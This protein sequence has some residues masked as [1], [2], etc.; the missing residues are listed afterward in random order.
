VD[1]GYDVSDYM[2]IDP[3]YG[4]MA[5]FDR[6]VAEAGK[7]NIRVICD[8]VVNHTSDR[9]RW[10]QES[11]TSRNNPKADWYVWRD[12]GWFGRLPN[13]WLSIFGHSA[14]QYDAARKQFYYHAFYKEQPDLNWRNPAV[15]KAMY[16]VM[17]F[18]MKRGVAGFRL[19]AVT[20][21]FEDPKLRDEAVGPDHVAHN[22]AAQLRDPKSLLNYYKTLIRLRRE[23][24]A[25]RDGAL[26]MV[27]ENNPGVL[28]FLRQSGTATVLVALNLSGQPQTVRYTLGGAG[29][30]HTLASSYGAPGN[31]E[32][33][34]VSAAGIRGLCGGSAVARC[35]RPPPRGRRGL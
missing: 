27:D 13:N 28:S 5:D 12:G 4:T 8:L 16:D 2:A 18:W 7:R 11:R 22:V 33:G 31:G 30:L 35:H 34:G 26:K 6:R 24:P 32:R 10:F 19:D 21:L 23:N 14:W 25:L 29:K 15:R 3:Q 1:F 17:R 9:R 20:S